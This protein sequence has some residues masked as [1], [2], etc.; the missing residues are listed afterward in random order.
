[1]TSARNR[2][3]GSPGAGRCNEFAQAPNLGRVSRTHL[4]PDLAGCKTR[5]DAAALLHHGGAD[6]GTRQASD[7]YINGFCHLT[8][9]VCPLGSLP[10][11]GLRSVLVEIA[12]CQIEA[13]SQDAAG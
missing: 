12:Y 10:K 8:G 6:G 3:V 7:Y 1:M 13:V 2:A 11:Q 4:R 9:R 5:D